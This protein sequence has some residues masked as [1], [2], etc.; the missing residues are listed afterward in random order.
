[1]HGRFGNI[2]WEDNIIRSCYVATPNDQSTLFTEKQKVI[3]HNN[4]DTTQ[5]SNIRNHATTLA[6][7]PPVMT[8]KWPGK[9]CKLHTSIVGNM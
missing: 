7:N 8:A 2:S 4:R 6:K 3:N 5:G 9:N 1:M